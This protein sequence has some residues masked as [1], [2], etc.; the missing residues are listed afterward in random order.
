MG[1][2]PLPSWLHPSPLHPGQVARIPPRAGDHREHPGAGGPIHVW[3][4]RRGLARRQGQ[5]GRRAALRS[6]NAHVRKWLHFS[7]RK[8]EVGAALAGRPAAPAARSGLP[9]VST[10]QSP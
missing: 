1:L 7:E 3:R 8:R 6:P 9:F 5:G 4:W 2:L 10:A